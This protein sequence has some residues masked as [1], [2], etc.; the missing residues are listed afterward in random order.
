MTTTNSKQYESVSP[1]IVKKKLSSTPL[2]QD[3]SWKARQIVACGV[4][5][6][7]IPLVFFVS[8]RK[9][10]ETLS[11]QHKEETKKEHLTKELYDRK[12][13]SMKMT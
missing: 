2:S 9:N 11:H 3:L 6:L 7:L 5:I 4:S 13:K 8:Q 1:T 10:N 12:I